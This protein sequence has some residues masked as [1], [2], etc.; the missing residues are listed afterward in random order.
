MDENVVVVVAEEVAFATIEHVADAA[1]M[2]MAE[3]VADAATMASTGAGRSQ[4][5]WHFAHSGHVTATMLLVVIKRIVVI[6]YPGFY[7]FL[8]YFLSSLVF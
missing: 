5:H 3:G 6:A 4:A 1:T 8:F 7:S 2:V